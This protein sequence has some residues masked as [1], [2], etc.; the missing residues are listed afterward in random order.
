MPSS[1][2]KCGRNR[3]KGVERSGE[4][5]LVALFVENEMDEKDV[6]PKNVPKARNVAR[7]LSLL[8]GAW[9]YDEFDQET[10][11]GQFGNRLQRRIRKSRRVRKR[12]SASI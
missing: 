9:S 4:K 1:R 10:G 12:L 3:S 7:A 5:V 2:A 8:D 11:K 6:S